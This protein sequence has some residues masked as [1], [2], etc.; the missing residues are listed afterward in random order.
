M[1]IRRNFI[2]KKI[3]QIQKYLDE[4]R[5]L[6]KLGDS[7][8]LHSPGNLHI[9]ERLLQLTVDAALDINNHIIKEL[10][11]DTADDFKGT[12]E[13]LAN[14]KILEKTF[15]EKINQV[16]GLRNRIVHQY[17]TVDNKQFISD[18]RKDIGDF[19]EYFKQIISYLDKNNF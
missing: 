5:D 8:I 3:E 4:A 16:V 11:L 15:A 6:F 7:E 18:F 19:D 2:T 1:T 14:G 17:E 10:R 13:I 12:F 9:A